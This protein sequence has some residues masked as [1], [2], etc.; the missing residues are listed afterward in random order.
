MGEHDRDSRSD[1]GAGAGATGDADAVHHLLRA[2]HEHLERIEHLVAADGRT[3]EARIAPAWQRA[4]AGE[5]RLP[6]AAFITVAIVLQVLLPARYLVGPR[7]VPV[8]LEAVLGAGLLVAN[9]RRI[10]RSSRALRG[11]SL[12]LIAMLSL[13]NAWSAVLLIDA[14]V[15]GRTG[16]NAAVLLGSGAAIYVTNVIVF[17]LWYWEFD[18]GGPVARARA[19]RPYPDFLFPQ[20]TNPELAPPD[21]STRFFDYLWLSYTNATAFSPTDVMPL[22]RWAKQLMLLQSAVSLVTVALVIARAVNVLK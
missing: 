18:R 1:A 17:A 3:I 5:H 14:L 19:R 7:L 8:V 2:V 6:V 11:A 22:S 21:W 16:S 13:A 4:T 15:R 9:P 20:M 10:N 12:L